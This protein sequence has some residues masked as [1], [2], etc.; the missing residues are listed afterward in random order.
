VSQNFV[1]TRKNALVLGV[2]GIVALLLLGLSLPITKSMWFTHYHGDEM[3]KVIQNYRSV[4]FALETRLHPERILSV[5]TNDYLPYYLE[6]NQVEMCQLCDRFWVVSSVEVKEI[7]VFEYTQ[8]SSRVWARVTSWGHRV[9][10]SSYQRLTTYE[11]PLQDD[12][13]YTFIRL[14]SLGEWKLQKVEGFSVPTP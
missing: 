10:V 4:E 13:T 2:L 3:K 7:Q 14:N 5:A 11:A 9:E 6:L 12:A 8:T 1:S